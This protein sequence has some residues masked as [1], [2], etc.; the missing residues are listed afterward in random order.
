M[1]KPH[2]RRGAGRAVKEPVSVKRKLG[3]VR[4]ISRHDLG[5]DRVN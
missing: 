4:R 1:C 3:K 5:S 2:K